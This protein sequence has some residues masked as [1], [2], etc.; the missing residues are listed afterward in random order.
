ME[1]DPKR[2]TSRGQLYTTQNFVD[3]EKLLKALNGIVDPDDVAIPRG[4]WWGERQAI[5]LGDGNHR[6]AVAYLNGQIIKIEIIRPFD[7]SKNPIP[8]NVFIR[9]HLSGM[10]L[11]Y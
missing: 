1:I 6:T 9:N 5:V 10:G 4:F 7:Q 2:L 3:Q 11:Q 8:F